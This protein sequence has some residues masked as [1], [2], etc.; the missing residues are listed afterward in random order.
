[1]TKNIAGIVDKFQRKVLRKI[2]NIEWQDKLTN[3]KLYNELQFTP[4]NISIVKRRL[5][6][7]GHLL[8]LP[9]SYPARLALIKAE[10]S[11]TRPKG[12]HTTTLLNI[13]ERDFS[14][15]NL[16]YRNRGYLASRRKLW[17]NTGYVHMS[18]KTGTVI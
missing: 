17:Y 2:F 5:K 18:H 10:N 1:M 14:D 8:R 7:F 4:W 9:P 3:M 15:I 6:W 13:V 11:Y 16:D 12:S